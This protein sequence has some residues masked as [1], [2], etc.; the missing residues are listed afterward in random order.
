MG[1]SNVQVG[2]TFDQP[3]TEFLKI[4]VEKKMDLVFY[5]RSIK[6]K[7]KDSSN[8]LSEMWRCEIPVGG[9]MQCCCYGYG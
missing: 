7:W 8:E 9:S 3:I 2:G 4:L 1:W 5:Q 6:A